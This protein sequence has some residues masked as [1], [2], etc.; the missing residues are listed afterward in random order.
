MY[1]DMRNGGVTLSTRGRDNSER[2]SHPNKRYETR[3]INLSQ[4]R[5]TTHNRYLFELD[6]D[7]CHPLRDRIG[8]VRIMHLTADERR[9]K[10]ADHAYRCFGNDAV[11]VVFVETVHDAWL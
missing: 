4:R 8:P 9:I 2:I 11:P 1:W 6:A 3:L 5:P 10:H 7:D